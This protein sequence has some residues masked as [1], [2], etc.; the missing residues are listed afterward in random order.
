M[1]IHPF[2]APYRI[3]TPR[4]VLRC[5]SPSDVPELQALIADNREH[6][7]P[8]VPWI[9]DEPKPLEEKLRELRSWRAAFDLDHEWFY[10]LLG[11]E[12]GALA[13]GLVVN[14]LSGAAVDVG[15][16]VAGALG[17]RG[18]HTEAASA[19][20]RAAFEVLGMTRVQATCDVDNERS[21][22]LLRKLGFT[23][24]ATPRHQVDG[25]RADEMVWSILAD[26]W[27]ATP[28]AAIAAGARAW[29]ALGNRL[30]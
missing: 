30:F 21:I 8:W 25:R 7:Q 27:P 2:G 11:A 29:D 28:A 13:G 22:A 3:E 9:A 20:T 12:S 6:L 23:H 1:P 19:A 24:E 17:H 18:Y 10:A 26:E 4:V 15:G 5:W 14:R 16:W